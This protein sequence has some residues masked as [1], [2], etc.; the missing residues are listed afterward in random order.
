MPVVAGCGN[1]AQ[2]IPTQDGALCQD[3]AQKV[4]QELPTIRQSLEE[5]QAMMDSNVGT[6]ANCGS[7]GALLPTTDGSLLCNDCCHDFDAN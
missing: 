7:V 5:L 2:L 6:C 3:C 1:T 4:E